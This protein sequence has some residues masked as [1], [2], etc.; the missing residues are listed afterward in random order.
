MIDQSLQHKWQAGFLPCIDGIVFGDGKVIVANT[1]TI[2]NHETKEQKYYWSALCDS[3]L[4]SFETYNDDLWVSVDIYKGEIAYKDQTIVFG[5][6]SMGHEGFVASVDQHNQLNWALFF[7]FTNPI[8]SAKIENHT[9][10][11]LSEI[12]MVISIDLHDLT[13]IK[14]NN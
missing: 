11:C 3:S 7:T 10:V 9:L 13:R 5:D 2:K 8:M 12:D 14:I 6:G 1:Y 4:Q